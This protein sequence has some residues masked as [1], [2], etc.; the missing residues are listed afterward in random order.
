MLLVSGYEIGSKL[1]NLLSTES[2]TA[3]V[4]KQGKYCGDLPPIREEKKTSLS[5]ATL[6]GM[7]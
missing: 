1:G 3:A 5:G 4:P 2:V 7:I 6:H